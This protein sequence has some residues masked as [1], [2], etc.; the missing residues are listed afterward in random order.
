[1]N[2]LTEHELN[3]IIMV[4]QNGLDI[5]QILDTF[6]ANNKATYDKTFKETCEEFG[7]TEDY[8]KSDDF[9]WTN[10]YDDFLSTL[11]WKLYRKYKLTALIERTCF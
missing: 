11:K 4:E 1:M 5:F 3:T 10:E 6:W 8:A 2:K 7:I 9:G